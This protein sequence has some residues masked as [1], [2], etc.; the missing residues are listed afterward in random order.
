MYLHFSDP[1][2]LANLAFHEAMHNKLALGNQGLH[3]LGGLANG[4]PNGTPP[5]WVEATTQLTPNNIS[6]MASALEA[7]R[8]QYRAGIAKV[9]AAV[10]APDSDPLKTI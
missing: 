9:A 8:P 5:G 3:P 6:R 2:L 7:V 1:D 4:T 10:A